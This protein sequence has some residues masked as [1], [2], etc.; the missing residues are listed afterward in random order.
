MAKK[1]KE[2]QIPEW[3]REARQAGIAGVIG[4]TASSLNSILYQ[5]KTEPEMSIIK[6]TFHKDSR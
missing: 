6:N 5:N 1:E 2:L 4:S 3:R